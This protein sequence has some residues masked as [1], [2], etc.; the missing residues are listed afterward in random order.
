MSEELAGGETKT[1]TLTWS[2]VEK[3]AEEMAKGS[4]YHVDPKS[5]DYIN[6]L[7]GQYFRNQ[8]HTF[9]NIPSFDEVSYEPNKDL[10]FTYTER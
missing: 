7:I 1:V 6:E 10:S 2:E 8:G 5:F 9:Y 4:R 3:L